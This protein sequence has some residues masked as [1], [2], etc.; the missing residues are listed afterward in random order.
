MTTKEKFLA[1]V[2]EDNFDT[3]KWAKEHQA[4]RKPRR[5]A[6]KISILILKRLKEL[7][8]SQKELAERMGVSPQLV[9]KGIKGKENNFSLEIL[10]RIGD[11]LQINLIEIPLI[12]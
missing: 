6:Q 11:N 7:E 9:N 1:L 12:D 2:T 4:N 8:W 3:M 10:S 5:A